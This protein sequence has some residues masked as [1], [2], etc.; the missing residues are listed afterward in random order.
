M[1]AMERTDRDGAATDGELMRRVRDGDLARLGELFERHARRLHHFFLRSTADRAAAEDLV[2][3]VFVRMLKY[4]GTFRDDAE[5][6]PWMWALA[7]HAAADGWRGRPR[8]QAV[9][10]AT[11]E[12][13]SPEPPPI[14]ALVEREQLDR[15]A[16]ALDRLPA[17]K[18]ELLLLAR[19]SELGYER[20]GE[21]LGISV[22]AV[23]VRVHRAL[24]DLRS[25]Y[26]AE[27]GEG[28]A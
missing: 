20:I 3:E 16:V 6:T 15:L 18:R 8:E 12:P 27:A 19:Y 11:P 21:L 10:E 22:G 5:F 28:A 23:K 26:L 2:Q 17:A 4:R 25:A 7:R 13:A 24:K 9:E 14:A 1:A